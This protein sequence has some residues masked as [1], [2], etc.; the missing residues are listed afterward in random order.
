M[1]KDTVIKKLRAH[2]GELRAEGV[3]HVFL[4][5]SVARG[6]QDERSDVDLFYDYDVDRFGFL[7][8]MRIRELA[9]RR[10][11]HHAPGRYSSANPSRCGAI[12]NPSLLMGTDEAA[13]VRLHDILR[14]IEGIHD[15]EGGLEYGHYTSVWSIKHASERGVEIISEASRHLPEALRKAEPDIPWRQ[16]AGVGNILR[17][18]YQTISDRVVWDIIVT[19]LEP[20]KAA[21]R[22][23][24]DKVQPGESA[25]RTP[26]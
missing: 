12:R 7:Q 20:L 14:A 1:D 5:G 9:R 11:R 19:H 2:E 26:P 13:R 23:L 17:H 15:T 18:G 16:I 24:L 4:F 8:F 6:E 25:T 10:R 22:R 21:V 3:S